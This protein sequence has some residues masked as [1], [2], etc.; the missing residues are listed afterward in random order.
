MSI[1]RCRL[2]PLFIMLLVVLVQGCVTV[3]S[4]TPVVVRTYALGE[5]GPAGGLVFYDKGEYSDGWR[6]LELAPVEVERPLQWGSYGEYIGETSPLIGRGKENTLRIVEALEARG[7]R[8]RAAQYST[9]LVWGGYSDWFLPSQ[10]ELDQIY[11][12]LG[13][14]ELAIFLGV[15][16]GY[17]SSTEYDQE[18]SWG[19]GFSAGVQGRIEKFDTFL[20]RPIRAF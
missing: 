14:K 8:G 5:R 19:Q 4:D 7:E 15:G 6:Y 3:D 10:Q 13:F 11:W 18:R 2:M 12:E 16:Y 17:W 1:K 20:V 9:E